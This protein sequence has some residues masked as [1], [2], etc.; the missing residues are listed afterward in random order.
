MSDNP[1][2]SVPA[3]ARALLRAADRAALATH[4]AATG[5]PY[6]SLVGLAT[7]LAGA[8]ILL[9]SELAEHSRGIARNPQVSLLIDGTGRHANPQAGPRL[10][11]MGRLDR[12][13]DEIAA[14]R[15]LAR[16]PGASRYAGFADFA[17]YRLTA[18]RAQLI[19]GFGRANWFVPTPALDEGAAAAMAA[20]MAAFLD[21]I[22]LCRD[23]L[24]LRLA[25]VCLRR[26]PTAAHMVA[27]DPDGCDLALG[28]GSGRRRRVVFTAPAASLDAIDRTLLAMLSGN[29]RCN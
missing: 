3:A 10:T 1:P 9:L 27:V 15:F 24:P 2:P 29:S 28:R 6:V 22:N 12:V 21:D 5:Q 4:H 26:R 14:R 18:Q 13:S 19:G 8:P 20:G 16:H 7:D 25:Q 17:F 11:L 23:G